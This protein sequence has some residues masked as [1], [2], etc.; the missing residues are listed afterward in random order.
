[1]IVAKQINEMDGIIDSAVINLIVKGDRLQMANSLF[2]QELAKWIRSGQNSSHDGI[3]AY[4]QGM[5][6]RLDVFAPIVSMIIRSFDLGKF[7][8][9]K[10]QKSAKAAP[11]LV[12]I[13]SKDDTVKDWLAT[14]EA[15]AHLMLKARVA[16]IWTS[17]FNQP[18]ELY[19]LRPQLQ[20]LFP[21]MAIHKFYYVLATQKKLNQPPED[22]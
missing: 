14:G 6:E 1:M 17:F 7:Q 3:P 4:A 20:A 16:D 19:E 22:R 21:K 13:N 15:L 2:R 9:D 8:A 10:D 12:L 5:D 11:L 18:I